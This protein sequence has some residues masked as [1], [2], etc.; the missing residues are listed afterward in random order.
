[1]DL[2]DGLD[3]GD[4][5]AMLGGTSQSASPV[6]GLLGSLLGGQSS[7]SPM[8]GLLGSLLG[9]GVQEND[10]SLNGNGLKRQYLLSAEKSKHTENNIRKNEQPVIKNE[11]NKGGM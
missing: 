6:G 1:M 11:M 5:M 3:L 8:G 10:N 9:S 2:S 7:A 4:V